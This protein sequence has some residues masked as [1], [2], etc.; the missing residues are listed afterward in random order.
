MFNVTRSSFNLT[1]SN[2]HSPEVLLELQRIF[3]GKCYL[4]EDIVHNP[5]KEHFVAKSNDETKEFDWSNL[6][7]VCKRCNSIKKDVIDRHNLPILDCCGSTIDVSWAIKCLCSTIP[8]EDFTVKAQYNDDVTKNTEILLHHCY[9]ADNANYGI[10]RDFL[11][12]QIFAEYV[13]FINH[14]RI[15][16][17]HKSLSSEKEKAIERLKNMSQNDY[18]FSI[19]WKWHIKSDTFLSAQIPG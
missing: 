17:S 12:E 18:P 4:C 11:H 5:D 8:N 15:V 2:F 3:Y 16:K 19:F 10:S 14:R 13:D 9:N 1:K 7:Y 6:Y